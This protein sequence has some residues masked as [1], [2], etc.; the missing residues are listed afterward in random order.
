MDN[1]QS[2]SKSRGCT[3]VLAFIGGIVV[4]LF[5]CSFF[6]L[7]LPSS[8]SASISHNVVYQ[9]TTDRDSSVYP[10]CFSFDTTYE[11][12]NGTAQ[13]R[14]SICNGDNTTVVDQFVG[15]R[16]D[17]V[18]LSLQNDEYWA[19]I[20]CEIYV[21]GKLLYQTYSEGQYIIASCSGTIP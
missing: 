4:V 1:S 12:A 15:S 8:S 13:K 20:G 6:G 21:D 11:M 10:S 5:A 14:A 3:N 19:Q 7:S 16:G 9:I 2:S 17:F 18:Y